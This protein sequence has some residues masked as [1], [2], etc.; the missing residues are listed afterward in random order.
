MS[1]SVTKIINHAT[2][3]EFVDIDNHLLA[4]AK[5]APETFTIVYGED[6]INNPDDDKFD[7]D[8]LKQMS[9]KSLKEIYE[10]LEKK[11]GEDM[12]KARKNSPKEIID[13]ILKAQ[14]E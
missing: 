7:S 2:G 5:S 14:E 13:A 11:L 12:P 9:M 6:I 8:G 10:L 3:K 4:Y 1:K